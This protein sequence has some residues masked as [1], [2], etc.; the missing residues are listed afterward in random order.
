ML[1]CVGPRGFPLQP[2]FL[3]C[4]VR[5]AC[6]GLTLCLAWQGNIED[7]NPLPQR[8]MNPPQRTRAGL[9]SRGP[10]LAS[11]LSGPQT[12]NRPKAWT[13]GRAP[14]GRGLGP[15]SCFG[16][17]DHSLAYLASPSCWD[18]I[19]PR[20]FS[21]ISSRATHISCKHVALAEHESYS[22]SEAVD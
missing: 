19:A 20:S 9:E 18:V 2:L 15:L 10:P 5:V 13:E 7:T 1:T 11:R 3:L 14:A 17:V 4:S 12:E 21:R 22:M 16:A 8:S 6:S